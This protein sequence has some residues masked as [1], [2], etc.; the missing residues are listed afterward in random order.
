MFVRSLDEGQTCA[1]K[2]D[3]VNLKIMLSTNHF[4]DFCTTHNITSTTLCVVVI[5]VVLLQYRHQR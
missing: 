2:I 3:K 4:F 1:T 5:M